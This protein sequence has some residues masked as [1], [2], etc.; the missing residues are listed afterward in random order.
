MAKIVYVHWNEAE[1]N[2]RV[3]PLRDAGH[4]V[5]VHWSTSERLAV[6][7]F[8]VEAVV[9]SLDRL[10]SHGREIAKWFAA[11]KKRQGIPL[12]FSGGDPEKVRLAR[13]LF[14]QAHTCS[15]EEIGRTLDKILPG[16]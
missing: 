13:G 8:A 6:G 5:R 10:P 9:I 11:A 1:A 12:I 4:Q 2:S 14:P 3:K 15:S 16:V 7:D